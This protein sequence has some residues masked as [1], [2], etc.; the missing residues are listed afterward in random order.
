MTK[1]PSR[2]RKSDSE[3]IYSDFKNIGHDIWVMIN[4]AKY[5]RI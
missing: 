2:F 1:R 5:E 3:Y 4:K